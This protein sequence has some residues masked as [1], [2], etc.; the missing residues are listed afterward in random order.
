M[1]FRSLFW[2]FSVISGG[3]TGE[4]N[5]V[6]F[7]GLCNPEGPNLEKIQDRP[8]GLKFSSEI[9]T[10]DILKRLK[11]SSEPPTKPLFILWA[12]LKAGIEKF[13]RD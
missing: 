1:Y 6:I 9:E 10:N 4:G 5:S 7:P 3:W 13:K 11:I 12:I 8:P 2:N